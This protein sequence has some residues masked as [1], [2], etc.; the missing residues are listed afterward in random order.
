MYQ[1]FAAQSST[2]VTIPSNYAMD[3]RDTSKV[4]NCKFR[5]SAGVWR[6]YT[7]INATTGAGVLST[8]PAG[9]GTGVHVM[10]HWHWVGE[11]LWRDAGHIEDTFVRSNANR[12][13]DTRYELS[14]KFKQHLLAQKQNAERDMNG[15]WNGTTRTTWVSAVAI[16]RAANSNNVNPATNP[17]GVHAANP[18]PQRQNPV[19]SHFWITGG[20]YITPGAYSSVSGNAISTDQ[21]WLW[22]SGQT[23][24]QF[25]GIST[26]DAAYSVPAAP[27]ACHVWAVDY[28]PFRGGQ[29]VYS[30]HLTFRTNNTAD[31]TCQTGTE[32]LV[33][34]NNLKVSLNRVLN[35][36]SGNYIWQ[37]PDAT[38]YGTWYHF[39]LGYK[40]GIVGQSMIMS[41]N[42]THGAAWFGSNAQSGNYDGYTNSIKD[43]SWTPYFG[44]SRYMNYYTGAFASV[45]GTFQDRVLLGGF[46][47]N[48]NMLV[49]SNTGTEDETLGIG[50]YVHALPNRN[51][52]VVY[53]DP[54]LATSPFEVSLDL[55]AG[56][57]ITCALQWYDDLFVGTTKNIFR[58]HGGDNLAVTPSN[59][60][61]SKVASVGTIRNGMTLTDDGIVFLGEAGVYKIYL[62][63]NTGA[64]R[65][66]NIGLKIRPEIKECM[67]RLRFTY[68]IGRI[69]YESTSNT[70]WVLFGD[71]YGSLYPRR[72]FVYFA[73][74][75]AWSEYSTYNGFMNAYTLNSIDDRIFLSLFDSGSTNTTVAE[76]NYEGYY[77]DL[78]TVTS[79]SDSVDVGYDLNEPTSTYA[80]GSYKSGSNVVLDL[81]SGIKAN[82]V[83]D[84][85]YSLVVSDGANTGVKGT[86]Y[87]RHKDNQVIVDGK[88]FWTGSETLSITLYQEESCNKVM[89][90]YHTGDE[91]W[92]GDSVLDWNG[93]LAVQSKV[94]SGYG[95]DAVVLSLSYPTWWVSPAFTRNDIKDLKR[96]KHFYAVLEN[97]VFA[98]NNTY[99][100]PSWE[101]LSEF[102]VS[103][104]QNGTLEGQNTSTVASNSL[105]DLNDES[106]AWLDYYRVSLPI[107]G[108]FV[109]FQ[110][111]IH[112]FDR[113]QWELVGY[114]I[115]TDPEGRTS[116]RAYND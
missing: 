7:S 32:T 54:E 46:Q 64:Y 26:T 59:F 94:G 69:G 84:Y 109:S 58:I 15:Q 113:G 39:G 97:N 50:I 4:T 6:S 30:T 37:V 112:S 56:E 18:Q 17:N 23:H 111:A 78:I 73:D 80:R 22:V 74:R 116:R 28:I 71:E 51:F 3:R 12:A 10:F 20:G 45:V 83:I 40:W 63:V 24:F 14:S 88:T 27:E 53:T 92:L 52:D 81:G 86:D 91:D 33:D 110:A 76:F 72:C 75:D 70:V 61:V 19:S 13:T 34:V 44:L 114:Q 47:S 62:D 68:S 107:K 85:D 29:G 106:P 95:G 25:G 108:S 38:T 87:R 66:N 104:I 41:D 35:D 89:N 5:D 8:T 98:V 82:P 55:E 21:T 90:V 1:A 100:D 2:S 105:R 16:R 93:Q 42:N 102:N 48:P 96:M 49:F 36:A 67:D 77:T 103:I 31:Y 99:T 101:A 65:V 60:F 79:L 9:N 43:G 11:S 115:E 57:R